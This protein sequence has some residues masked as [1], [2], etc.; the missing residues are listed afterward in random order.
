MNKKA[1]EINVATIIIVIL[2]ILVLVILALYFTGGMKALWGKITP[3]PGA[4]EQTDIEQTR[5][6][7][8]LYCSARDETSFCTHQFTIRTVLE[9]K[10]TGTVTKYCDDT[11]PK[12]IGAI[13]QNECISAGF[14]KIDCEAKYGPRE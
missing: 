10:V 11:E 6:A 7:C 5:N 9:G 2:A 13:K 3:V 1:I 12:G 8:T 14:D 4:Y